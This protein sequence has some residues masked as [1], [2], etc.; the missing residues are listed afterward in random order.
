MTAIKTQTKKGLPG[1]TGIAWLLAR[2]RVWP[3]PP[4]L[5][6]RKFLSRAVLG[7][8]GTRWG[9]VGVGL[10]LRCWEGVDQG[11]SGISS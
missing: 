9:G 11:A 1:G 7:G 3:I 2:V 4:R 10:S 6:C 8:E 5:R